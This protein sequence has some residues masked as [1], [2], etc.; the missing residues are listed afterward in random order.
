[1]YMK[2]SSGVTK[3]PKPLNSEGW[4]WDPFLSPD[5]GYM[6]FCSNR[7]ATKDKN[8]DIFVSFKQSASTWGPAIALAPEINTGEFET[9]A[10]ITDDGKYML[11]TRNYDSG[12][13]HFIVSTRVIESL[14]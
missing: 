12:M 5:G 11:F 10:T 2:T 6:V 3:L 9:A 4:E 1:M 13:Q 7:N 8:T 14:K